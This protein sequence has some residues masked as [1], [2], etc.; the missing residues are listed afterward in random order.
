MGRRSSSSNSVRDERLDL[1]LGADWSDPSREV[2]D[3]VRR[4]PAIQV[5][6]T[7]VFGYDAIQLNV[8]PGRLFA[9]RRLR[10]ALE[11]CIDKAAT[12]D[13]ATSGAARP[14]DSYIPTGSWAYQGEFSAGRR[15]VD[16]GRALIESAGWTKA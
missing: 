16:A 7:P 1:W 6:D 10:Q 3:A 9:D 13:A 4:E 2:V 5:L 11:L 15:D 8:H 12:V 14:V